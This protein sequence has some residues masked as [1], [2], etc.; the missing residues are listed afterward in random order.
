MTDRS[1]T[2]QPTEHASP[3]MRNIIWVAM[4]ALIASAL[5]CVVWV[6]VGNQDGLIGRAFLTIVLLAGFAAIA[7]AVAHGVGSRPTWLSRAQLVVWIVVVL[8]GAVKIWM[9]RG[10]ESWGWATERFF[11]F[12]LVIGL[13]HLA[14]LHVRLYVTA[15]LR[16]VTTA[17]KAISYVTL[18]LLGILVVMLVVYLTVPHLFYYPDVYWRIVASLAILVAVGTIMIPLLNAQFAPRQPKAARVRYGTTSNGWPTY[19]DGRTP[20]PQLADGKPDWAAYYA[21]LQSW[22]AAAPAAAVAAEAPAEVLAPEPVAEAPVVAD[23]AVEA[24]P[25]D[26]ASELFASLAEQGEPTPKA[27]ETKPAAKPRAKAA[28]KKPAAR[29]PRTA[30]SRD[31]FPPPPPAAQ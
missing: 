3:V 13:L 21:H 31:E 26:A 2:P 12:L 23:T 6:L 17:T 11:H 16:Y 15:S 29:S 1:P 20:L 22:Q 4:G 18:A 28:A 5:V 25:A 30:T 10:E 27:A 9:P 19:A 7:L 14:L 24:T 8:V